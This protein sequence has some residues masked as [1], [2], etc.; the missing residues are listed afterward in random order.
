MEA[1]YNLDL[2]KNN[3]NSSNQDILSSLLPIVGE[4]N[5]KHVVD[6]MNKAENKADIDEIC[7]ILINQSKPPSIGNTV[8][9]FI[10]LDYFCMF[11]Y[12]FLYILHVCIQCHTSLQL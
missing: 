7:Y 2:I 3:T 6:A 5:K 1:N 11:T 10:R 12:F 4:K 9:S 8:F